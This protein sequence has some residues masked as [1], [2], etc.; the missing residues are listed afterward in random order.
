MVNIFIVDR[1]RLLNDPDRSHPQFIR[2]AQL[3]RV[4]ELIV[5]PK[6]P[7]SRFVRVVDIAYANNRDMVGLLVDED[8]TQ[9]ADRRWT[10]DVWDDIF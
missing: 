4:G 2:L 10:A 1:T 9:S 8:G 7:K 5:I 3:P 6:H